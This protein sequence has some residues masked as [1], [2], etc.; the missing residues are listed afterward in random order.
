LAG[1][2]SYPAIAVTVNVAANAASP[3]VNSVSVSGGGSATESGSD[4]TV[5]FGFSVSVT[6]PS[7]SAIAGSVVALNY[8]I[9]VATSGGFNSPVTL[10]LSGLPAGVA[11]VWSSEFASP[12][13]T[14]A[15]INLTVGSGTTPGIYSLTI[16][17]ANGG[18]STQSTAQVALIVQPPKFTITISPSPQSVAPGVTANYTITALSSTGYSQPISLNWWIPTNWNTPEGGGIS[19]L[20]CEPGEDQIATGGNLPASIS[21]GQQVIASITT[22]LGFTPAQTVNCDF[23]IA[24][25]SGAG[26]SEYGAFVGGEMQVT[27]SPDYNFPVP[28]PQTVTPPGTAVYTL[29]VTSINSFAGLVN[30]SGAVST[31]VPAGITVNDIS[32]ISGGSGSTTMTV[33]VP[34]GYPVGTY[35]ITISSSSPAAAQSHTDL[36]LLTVGQG[37]DF[38]LT[39]SPSQNI[40]QGQSASYTISMAPAGGVRHESD[41]LRVSLFCTL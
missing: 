25:G 41:D 34:G 26:S 18:I 9:S 4:S 36:V 21:V 23:I 38:T 8:P 7:Q 37:A 31:G 12:G 14:P 27:P 28:S 10:S 35:G 11:S 20:S 15:A 22:P 6:P 17:G 13:Q 16:T 1:G 19:G 30:F 40:Q 24:A 39:A 33:N 29:N 32:P 3:Q 5:I 2:Y